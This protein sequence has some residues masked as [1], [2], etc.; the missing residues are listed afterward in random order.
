MASTL[1]APCSRAK[2]APCSAT[3]SAAPEHIGFRHT[4]VLDAFELREAG[5][6]Q[7][8]TVDLLDMHHQ[9]RRSL[10]AG[11]IRRELQGLL[12]GQRPV[13]RAQDQTDVHGLR[14]LM[15][16]RCHFMTA[17]RERL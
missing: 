8:G 13:G 2:R 1:G 9:E 12:R 6:H 16:R 3:R 7:R 11:E 4:D 10:L 15:D 17:D 14:P 5:G